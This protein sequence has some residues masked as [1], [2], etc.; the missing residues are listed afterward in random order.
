M[1][2]GWHVLTLA[3]GVEDHAQPVHPGTLSLRLDEVRT[4]GLGR[5]I[6]F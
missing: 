1:I 3:P 2:G 6:R 5:P 4:A